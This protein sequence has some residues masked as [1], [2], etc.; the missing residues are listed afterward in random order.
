[1]ADNDM[2]V[3]GAKGDINHL[4]KIQTN[5]PE[6]N[7]LREDAMRAE[8]NERNMGLMDGLRNYPSAVFWSFAI[9]LCISEY[10][11]GGAVVRRH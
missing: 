4:E 2:E 1:M 11:A 5:T 8:E 7:N 10:P 3:V 9:S 6:W